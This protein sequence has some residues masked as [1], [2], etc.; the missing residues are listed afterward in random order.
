MRNN[1]E[2]S[3]IQDPLLKLSGVLTSVSLNLPED[4]SEDAWKRVGSE[5]GRI[6]TARIWWIGDWWAF[7]E[8]KY[9]DRKALVDGDG[10]T[11]PVFQT[12]KDAAWVCRRFET[13]RRRDLLSFPVHREVAA[14]D[15][16]R[17]DSLLDWCEAPLKRGAKNPKTIHQLRDEILRRKNEQVL[18]AAI[19]YIDNVLL[20]YSDRPKEELA[21]AREAATTALKELVELA[22]RDKSIASG[23]VLQ[24]LVDKAIED[25][26]GIARPDVAT[27][28]R[29]IGTVEDLTEDDFDPEALSQAQPEV[30][31][32]RDVAICEAAIERVGAFINNV[33]TRFGQ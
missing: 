10:W 13:S 9:G 31:F 12:C 4:L 6:D 11:G 2:L 30:S 29:F 21:R 27:Y 18:L 7:G 16:E 17:A 5:L 22:D 8:H 20:R 15:P 24:N 28:A 19:G 33:K 3:V 14:F 26:F 1:N 32:E 25:L 23:L